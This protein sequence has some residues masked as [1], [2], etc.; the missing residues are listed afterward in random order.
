MLRPKRLSD[1][2]YLEN[3]E[4]CR[5]GLSEKLALTDVLPSVK[6]G[7]EEQNKQTAGKEVNA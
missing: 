6:V 2:Q 3:F 5:T 4:A 7:P 1:K